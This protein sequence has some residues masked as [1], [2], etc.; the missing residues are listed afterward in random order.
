MYSIE[1][2]KNRQYIG[3]N[4]RNAHYTLTNIPTNINVLDLKPGYLPNGDELI[5]TNGSITNPYFVIDKLFEKDSRHRIINMASVKF[6]YF[7]GLY[8]QVKVMQDYY[9][10][11]RMNYQ[12]MGMNWQPFDGEITQRWNDFQEMNYEFTT[13]YNKDFSKN[14]SISA[15]VG[16]NIRKPTSQRVNMYGTPFVVPEVFTLNNTINKTISTSTTVSQINSIFG[17]LELG[18]KNYLFLTMTGRQDWFSTLPME[19]N[20][21]FYPAGSLSFIFTDAFHLPKEIISHGK[22]RAS[23]AQVSGGADPYSLDLSYGLDDKNYDGQVLQGISTTTIPNKKLKPLISTEYEFGLE[24]SFANGLVTADIAYYN[25]R[26]KDDIVSINVSNAS[27]FNKAI[28]NT[29]KIQNSGVEVMLSAN[30]FMNSDFQWTITGTYSKNYNKI[31]SLGDVSSIQIGAAK[32]D[33][34]TVNIDKDEPYGII[35]GSVYKRDDQ[36]NIVFDADGY[37]MVGD[38]S[39]KLGKGY[40]D[41]IAG[42]MNKFSY[43]GF[44]M[45]IL[46]DAK[47]GGSLYSQTNRWAVSAGKHKMTLVGREDGITGVG[48]K[49]DGSVNDIF[50]DPSRISSYY[51]RLTT[52]HE[53]FVYD[54]GFIKFR[55]LSL[56]YNFPY[57]WI[58]KTPIKTLGATLVA[59]NLFYL[60]NK[61]DNV[62][63]ESSISSS[64]AQ[65]LENSGYPETRYF[66]I[67]LNMS[68]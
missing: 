68:F 41:Q 53:N 46:L 63:P 37:P 56:G 8:S 32:N 45:N 47:F 19:N 62:S 31:I 49:E 44:S 3:G 7:K 50:V 4:V 26:I 18:L 17:M 61:I 21:L 12:P 67:N 30:P 10:F 9:F 2:V 22:L 33:V 43:K 39:T 34:V 35:K 42:L 6:D 64:N 65:G 48:V 1:N 60:R 11:K 40:H 13:G 54:A 51:G 24:T 14:Y 52:I 36:G 55:E 25:K 59:R 23:I 28:M 16:A 27:G 38:R 58:E 5:F 20:N 15:L 57:N 66:G 29:G